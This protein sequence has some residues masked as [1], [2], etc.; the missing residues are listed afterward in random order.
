M[1]T[2]SYTTR[3]TDLRMPARELDARSRRA[4]EEPMAVTAFGT[5]LYEVESASGETYTV[6][7]DSCRCTCPDHMFRN[8]RCKHLRRV[9][10]EITERRVPP[11]G[12]VVDHCTVCG[13]LLHVE[14][15]APEP[16]LC[17]E[18]ELRPGTLVR[19]RE[20]GGQLLVV[21]RSDRRADETIVE[22]SHTVAD[23]HSN[24]AYPEDD[25]IVLAVYPGSLR[26]TRDGPVPPS[27]RVYS[28][29]R[30]RLVPVGA[31]PNDGAGES[32]R[33]RA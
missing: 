5:S 1:T 16:R 28:F 14:R 31:E 23:H 26:M 9:A 6:D 15:D 18:H 25:P 11:P 13:D 32:H 24:A 21:G 4:R 22:G 12:Y 10:I 33:A 19:D 3:P 7:I 27:L 17:S 20:Q 2:E 8:A 29:P 30:S